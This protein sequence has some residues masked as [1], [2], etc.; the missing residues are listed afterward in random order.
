MRTK[1]QLAALFALCLSF[2]AD[3]AESEDRRERFKEL[4]RRYAETTEPASATTL[5]S[6]LFALADAE[7]LDNLSTGGPFASAAFIQERLEAFAEEWGGA[8]FRILQPEGQ[9][10]NTLTFVLGTMTRGEPRASLR[11][12]ARTLGRASLRTGVIH[13][14][15][16]EFHAWPAGRDGS[17]R[18]LISWLGS[19][20]GRGSRP[21]HLELW[22]HGGRED[23]TRVWTSD[24]AFSTGLWVTDFAAQGGQ[25]R[26]RY[27]ARYP[28]WRPGCEDET[29]HE[30][31]YH[32][33]AG[34]DQLV[35][36]HRRVVNGWHRELHAVVAR[37]FEALS[38]GDG[39]TLAELV[40]D[41]SLRRRL[42]RRLEP[43]SACDQR[44]PRV[45]ATVIVASRR[46]RDGEIEPWSLAWRRGPRG[47]RLAAA[48]PVLQ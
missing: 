38:A 27:E 42:P 12:Y 14:G 48:L 39:K 17:F 22:Q 1:W 2:P 5:L 31:V 19:P 4:A 21:L 30:D 13:D 37:F 24:D 43:D 47:W 34:S 45:P 23:I 25:V 11:V 6:E 15:A 10:K 8:T 41:E 29:E 40:P 7:V 33:P 20:T 16:A 28:G 44:N 46:S 9:T 18:V 35:L 32:Q 26:L 36:R 3:A